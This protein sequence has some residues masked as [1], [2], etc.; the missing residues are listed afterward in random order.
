MIIWFV[1]WSGVHAWAK[2][3][4]AL[5]PWSTLSVALHMH[6]C[7]IV[8]QFLRRTA[9]RLRRWCFLDEVAA[10][11]LFLL[12]AWVGIV[13][14]LE[15]CINTTSLTILFLKPLRKCRLGSWAISI[16]Y[17]RWLCIVLGLIRGLNMVQMWLF[18]R[19]R[20]N[21]PVKVRLIHSFFSSF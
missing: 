20:S 9:T 19:M 12:R 4:W 10:W 5:M 21:G 18:K 16:R 17:L 13:F 11:T 6:H 3:C 2:R 1:V 7:H 15:L 14:G 8:L